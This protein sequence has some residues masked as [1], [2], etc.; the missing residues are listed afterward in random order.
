MD[1]VIKTKVNQD[2]KAVFAGFNENLFKA[3]APPFP[4]VKVLRFDGCQK[5]DLVELELDLIFSKQLWTARIIDFCQEDDIVYFID[6]GEKLPFFLK[7]WYHKHSIQKV[8]NKAY[9]IDDIYFDSG[10]I[11]TNFLMLPVLYLQFLYRV[12][13]YKKYFK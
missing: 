13:I 10:N 5:G 1:I 6:K 11:F 9:I 3:L 7:S 12:P 2:F 8:G 4:P